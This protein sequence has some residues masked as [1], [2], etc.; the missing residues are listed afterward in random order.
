MKETE[1]IELKKSTSELKPGVI[2]IASM[3]NKSG[4]G[5]LYFGI[6][7]DGSVCGQQ[8][9]EKTTRDVS[10]A[11]KDNIKPN[12]VPSIETV[13]M[14]GKEVIKV[15]CRGEDTPYSAYNRYY[16]RS[17]DEDLIMSTA[18]LE[19]FL[20]NKNYDYSK[21]EKK[22]SGHG[23]DS[24]DEDLLIEYVNEGNDTGRIGFIYRDAKTT[25][26]KLN[27][28]VADELNNAGYYLF[29][30]QKP[31]TLKLAIYPTDERLSFVDMKTYK[32]NIFECINEAEKYI[33]NNIHWK[34]E[35]IGTKRVEVPEIPVEAIREIIVNSFAH[36]RINES[37]ANEIYITPT[38]V[39][40][41]NP[42]SMVP[43][44]TPE[45]FASGEQGSMIRNPIIASV[46]YYNHTIDAFGT[47][48]E[49]VFRL[50]RDIE[51]KYRNNTFGFT[52]EFIRKPYD[53]IKDVTN[54]AITIEQG[55]HLSSIEKKLYK[56]IE[57]G[58]RHTKAEYAEMIGM[59]VATVDRAIKKLTE[60]GLIRRIGANRNGS[61]EITD[62]QQ[63]TV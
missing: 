15:V 56:L 47:G 9:G 51:Y 60:A 59:S 61:W 26:E 62:P 12:I 17:D 43:G 30:K 32:G 19:S 31:L 57:T 5:E 7:N 36:M 23:I 10:V 63:K 37:S 11:I 21:W 2:S 50:C 34:A 27:L 54:E 14:D 16:I 3:L 13:T 4:Y 20:L 40:I 44:T 52:F 53:V 1:Q 18:D 45:M 24:I 41:Y 58:E 29:S 38:R 39:H 55:M 48:F 6:R 35:I 22:K 42:G 28:I 33:Q 46:L 8:I 25:L 49:R